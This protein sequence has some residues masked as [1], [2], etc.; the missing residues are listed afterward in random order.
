MRQR[1]FD[2]SQKTV[3]R[4]D[5]RRKIDPLFVAL[6][7]VVILVAGLAG[8]LWS[9]RAGLAQGLYRLAK[10]D[11]KAGRI[12]IMLDRCAVA[13]ALYPWN[14]YFSIMAA[15]SAYYGSGVPNS[16]QWKARLQLS[17]CWCDRGLLQN[18]WKSQLR[19]L[20][21][22]FLWEESPR[23]ATAYWQAHTDWQYWEPHN[24]AVLSEMYARMGNFSRADQELRLIADFPEAAE[25]RRTVLQQ[26]QEWDAML[27]GRLSGWGE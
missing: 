22:R 24:H 3:M 18:P 7:G 8:G 23:A 13:H 4:P 9:V 17:R 10:H 27:G 15:E 14:Y 5:K 25:T 16:P 11:Q 12:D 2:A 26:R 6:V 19:R 1:G 21:T 20:K